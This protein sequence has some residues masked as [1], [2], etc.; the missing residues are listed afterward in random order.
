MFKLLP[1]LIVIVSI[2]VVIIIVLRR[3]PQVIVKEDNGIVAGPET[4]FLP[5]VWLA[6]FFRSVRRVFSTFVSVLISSFKK[7]SGKGF[8]KTER[9]K[10]LA[11]QKIGSK[12]IFQR[13]KISPKL[14][15]ADS[16]VE[17]NDLEQA[18]QVFIKVIE[19]EP[20]NTEAYEGLG[21]LYLDRKK[22]K[23]ALEVYNHLRKLDPDS[24]NYYSKLG[25]IYF[26]LGNYD[27]AIA[28]YSK[29]I[30]LRSDTP[31]RLANLSLCYNAKDML[32]EA[33]DAI[34]RAL[35]ISPA[36]SQYL[37]LLADYTAKGGKKEQALEILEKVLELE[38]TNQVARQKLM[39]LKF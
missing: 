16:F 15:E 3:L 20:T 33:V 26:N 27:Q 35:R 8:L 32:P 1:Q 36:N 28:A 22:Y 5:L 7:R 23:D 24:D 10:S 12:F 25:L 37:L 30:I 17:A 6:S 39:E 21:K 29:A 2:L 31:H 19:G 9:L 14:L 13:K 11:W 38:P 4:Q 18:E 34:E